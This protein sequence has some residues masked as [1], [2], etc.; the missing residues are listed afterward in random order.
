MSENNKWYIFCDPETSQISA[1]RLTGSVSVGGNISHSFHGSIQTNDHNVHAS[2]SFT[3]IYT[4]YFSLTKAHSSETF[5]KVNAIFIN[6]K[7]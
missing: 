4:I 2:E 7:S 6:H 1:F 5:H 3:K